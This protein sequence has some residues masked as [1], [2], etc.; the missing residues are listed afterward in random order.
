VSLIVYPFRL[1]DGTVAYVELPPEFGQDDVERLCE[2]VRSIAT[3]NAEAVD[4]LVALNDVIA[5]PTTGDEK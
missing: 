4:E 1:Q 3:D 2:F 5:V